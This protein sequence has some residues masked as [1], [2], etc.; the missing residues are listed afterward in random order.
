MLAEHSRTIDLF[1]SQVRIHVGSP[2]SG[3]LLP[4]E[5]AAIMVEA[6]LRKSH[7]E[8]SRFDSASSLSALN[9]DPTDNIVVSPHVAVLVRAAV[10]SAR[11]SGGL[12]DPTLVVA[13]EENGYARSRVGYESAP[14]TDALADAPPRAPATPAP[15]GGWKRITVDVASN[16]VKRP[17]GLRLDSGGVGKGLAADLA[18]A[19]LR[20]YTS[21][22]VDCGGDLRIGGS[23]D[24]SRRVSV[25]HPL[26]GDE[27]SAFELAAGAVATSGLRS[28]IWRHDGGFAHHLIDPGTG[29]PAWTGLLQATALAPTALE[30]ETLAKAALLSGPA[31]APYWLRKYGG[32]LVD[33]AGHV[34]RVT[35]T[36]PLPGWRSDA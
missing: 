31:A 25:E 17:P 20:S 26:C 33:D 29:R 1:G 21:F 23:A 13:L 27:A 36:A 19:Q 9:D 14:L 8:L 16:T 4:P 6:A 32:V 34:E 30:S 10:A 7:S 12:V 3:G 11:A 15:A 35:P 5:L 2:T 24:L 28:R 18:S 22:C